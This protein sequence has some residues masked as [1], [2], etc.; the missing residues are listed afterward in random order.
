[1]YLWMLTLTM[2]APRSGQLFI[3][4]IWSSQWTYLSKD[5]CP[6]LE[7]LKNHPQPFG[8]CSFRK[9]GITNPI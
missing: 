8:Q 7:D 4:N 6:K 3:V 1:M 2:I 9:W 5:D